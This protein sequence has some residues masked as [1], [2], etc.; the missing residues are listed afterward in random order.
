MKDKTVR[1]SLIAPYIDTFPSVVAA[2]TSLCI[3]S[4]DAIGRCLA[5]SGHI[6]GA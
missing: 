3:P 5:F 2:A 4:V 1:K 6:V